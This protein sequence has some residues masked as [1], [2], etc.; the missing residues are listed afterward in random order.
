M[1]SNASKPLR[2]KPPPSAVVAE[3]WAPFEDFL[4]KERRYSDY[5]LRNY[6][7]AF[8]DFYRWLAGSGLWDKGLDAL[9]A[10]ET[11]DF[12]IEAQRRFDRRT[13]HNHVSGLRTFFKYWLRQ[14]KVRRNPFT[15]VPLPK[16][17]KRLPQFLTEEQMKLL[18]T[19]PQ[20]LLENGGIDAFSAWRDRLAMELLYVRT[21]GER[22][23]GPQS[24]CD[25]FRGGG[26]AGARQGKEGTALSA[27]A[28]GDECIEQ[29][30]S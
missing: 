15:G 23:H 25:R 12:V 17:E 3:W 28:G 4:G 16:L 29:I 26:R 5:T 21:A 7:Q 13:L 1:S 14:G 6:R 19:G 10:R 22:T 2:F 8:G 24:L 11:R 9:S 30:Q 18:L 27:R 20:R